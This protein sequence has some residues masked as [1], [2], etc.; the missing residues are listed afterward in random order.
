[1]H[2]KLRT[3]TID[4]R[5]TVY[6]PIEYTATILMYMKSK[7]TLWGRKRPP[8]GSKTTPSGVENDPL[9]GRKR[10]PV[11]SKTTPSGVENDPLWGRKRPHVGSK[12]TPFEV[13]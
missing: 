12:T 13:I 10:P 6:C 7:D 11:G 9:W 8:V 4:V 5:H 2:T 1:M 3:Q